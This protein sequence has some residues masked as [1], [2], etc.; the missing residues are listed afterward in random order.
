MHIQALNKNWKLRSEEL[1]YDKGYYA[2]VSEKRDGWYDVKTLPCDIH[3]PLIEKGE[4]GDPVIADNCFKCEWIENRSWW[5]KKVFKAGKELTKSQNSELVIDR[6]DAEADLFLNGVHLGHHKSATFPF[7]KDIRDILNEGENTLVIRVTLGLESYSEIELSKIKD[8]IHAVYKSSGEPRGDER[9]VFVRKP[10][11][12]YG[13]DWNLRIATCGIKGDAKIEAYNEIAIRN[14]KFTTNKLSIE[15]AEVTIEAEIDNLYPIETLNAVMDLEISFEGSAVQTMQ[16]DLFMTAGINYVT[17]NLTIDE[18]KLWWPNGMGEQDLYKIKISASTPK[19]SSDDYEFKAGI[20]TVKLN[21]D[22]IDD[23]S[24]M[25]F[26]EINGV[27]LFGK[28]GNWETP[29]S[30]YGRITDEKYERLISEAKEANFNMFRFNGVNAYERDYFYD[31]CDRYG[32]LI[33]QDFT[34]SCSAYPDEVE[35]FRHEVEKEIDYQTKRL[36]NHPCIALWNGSNECQW[37]LTRFS[38]GGDSYFEGDKKPASPGGTIMWNEIMPRTI[39]NNCPDIPYWNSSP[40]GGKDLNSDEYGSNHRWQTGFMNDDMMVRITPEKYDKIACKFIA[41]FGCV[42]P[43][44]KSTIYKYYGSENIDIESSVWKLHTNTFEKETIKAA[45]A[46]HYTNPESLSLDGYLLYAGLFQGLMLGYAFES[47]RNAKNN[48][49]GLVWS[50]NDCWGEVGWSII[51]YYL[52]RKISF[53]FVKRALAHKRLILRESQN[54][55]NVICLNDTREL[56]EFDLEFG[57]QTFEGE[58]KNSEVKKVVVQPSSKAVIIAKFK[59]GSHDI[60]KGA[61]YA[62]PNEKSGMI[63]AL[64]RSTDFKDLQILQPEI[65]VSD[66]KV[67]GES[68]VFKV[69]SD[70]YVHGLHFGFRD[71]VLLSDEYFDLLAGESRE[72]IISGI[73]AP[74][75]IDKI[76]PKYVYVR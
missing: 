30:L 6:L 13:W 75:S 49:G 57:Y 61:Y 7:R 42:G 24:R 74:S 68:T 26:F 37:T 28:G 65:R 70:K 66:L 45:I 59:K 17:F 16:K 14:V 50:F 76:N 20:R 60:L 18:P 33:W 10:A 44:K 71:D 23:S 32:I 4:M 41:E 27:P 5:F 64:L 2:E 62:W 22:K 11:Y 72:I 51:D 12:V 21:T 15:S 47:M 40:F 29:D 34:F 38:K 43:T 73:D 25:F 1:Y 31:C 8:F 46:K 35:W 36:R 54:M 3:V 63:P 9:R 19:G 53:Y 55:V 69:T 52:V 48:Y 58:K 56:L 67:S 39:H